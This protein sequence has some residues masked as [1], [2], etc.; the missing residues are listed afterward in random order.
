MLICDYIGS[1]YPGGKG[2]HKAFFALLPRKAS[3]DITRNLV[4]LMVNYGV[5]V[6]EYCDGLAPYQ[7]LKSLPI[8]DP[9]T[10]PL[11]LIQAAAL[12]TKSDDMLTDIDQEAVAYESFKMSEFS[13]R[14]VNTELSRGIGLINTHDCK[15]VRHYAARF[16]ADLLSDAPSVEDLD[17][18]FGPGAN[19]SSRGDK[20]TSPNVKLS[21]K[22]TIS[23]SL[24]PF[25][26]QLEPTFPFVKDP[27]MT[28]G[29]L[30]FVAK[31]FKTKR[32]VLIEPNVNSALQKGAGK[33]IRNALRRCGLLTPDAQTI[34]RQR[35]LRGSVGDD[36]VTIDLSRA[37]D[38]IAYMLVM[39]LLP[40]GWFSLLDSLR[41]PLARYRKE[42]IELE[43]FSSMG[44]GFTFELETLL[45][46]AIIRGVAAHEGLKDDSMVY[47]DDITCN[48]ALGSALVKYLPMFG[49]EVNASK[50]F[51]EGPF[52]EACGGDY[53]LG[54]D[55]RPWFLRSLRDGGRWNMAKIFSFYNFLQRKPWFDFGLSAYL[56][57]LVPEHFKTFGPDG[58]GDGH[59]V[60]DSPLKLWVEGTRYYNQQC[61]SFYTYA[62]TPYKV[63]QEAHPALPAYATYAGLSAEDLYAFDECRYPK[64]IMLISQR[65][66]LYVVPEGGRLRTVSY[67]SGQ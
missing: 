40:F 35:A 49:F 18:T 23:N 42:L 16:I 66:R 21:G 10:A 36:F 3:D 14:T 2:A 67:V 20:H 62:A 43:K 57:S 6:P 15:Q 38:S 8:V 33:H 7:Y 64:G 48:A 50:S 60:S 13:C 17:F 26:K 63:P 12:F 22:F 37:S 56:L 25:W 46:K 53:R 28:C 24:V 55:V 9:V 11:G 27:I 34:Q 58:F 54:Q 47:G 59:L 52:R 61:F 44:N 51:F 30:E 39:D 19:V 1:S 32:S 5:D 29:R 41:T 45:F 65:K 4:N 31:N